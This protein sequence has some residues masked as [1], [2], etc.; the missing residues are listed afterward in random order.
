MHFGGEFGQADQREGAVY[1]NPDVSL[2]L[3]G[4]VGTTDGEAR[5]GLLGVHGGSYSGSLSIARGAD[6]EGGARTSETEAVALEGARRL[7]TSAP[8]SVN[9]RRIAGTAPAPT[10]VDTVQRRRSDGFGFI[11][12]HPR[13][14]LGEHT[15]TRQSG[16]ETTA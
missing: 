11:H 12:K 3:V 9:P 14:A 16:G 1:Q 10:T 4:G 8:T 13:G 15:E 6:G 7:H 2:G 5:H